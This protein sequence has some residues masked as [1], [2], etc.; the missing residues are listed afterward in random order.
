MEMANVKR[1]C[2]VIAI[3]GEWKNDKKEGKGIEMLNGVLYEGGF[4][5]DM[6]RF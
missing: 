5:N 3:V 1:Y 2:F 6:V 4:K